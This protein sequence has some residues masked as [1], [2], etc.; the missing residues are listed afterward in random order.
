MS[1]IARSGFETDG[2]RFEA[3]EAVPN[4]A[5][6]PDAA[7][8]LLEKRIIETADDAEAPKPKKKKGEG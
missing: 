8:W 2:R 1:W 5:L 6:S 7:A 3:G 4:A